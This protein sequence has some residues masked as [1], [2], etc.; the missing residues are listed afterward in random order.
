MFLA[1]VCVLLCMFAR[2]VLCLSARASITFCGGGGCGGA[3]FAGDGRACQGCCFVLT[4]GAA[5]GTC[6]RAEEDCQRNV[7]QETRRG[8]Y[9]VLDR[10]G[11][12]EYPRRE[13]RYRVLKEGGYS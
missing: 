7:A 1:C 5:V 11:T 3:A 12:R 6:W 9:S 4:P 2:V 10:R 13:G 8:E